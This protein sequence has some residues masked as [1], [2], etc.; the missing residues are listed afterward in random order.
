MLLNEIA[1]ICI[2]SWLSH[3]MGLSTHAEHEG[4]FALLEAVTT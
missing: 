4:G 1:Y 3:P 2:Y